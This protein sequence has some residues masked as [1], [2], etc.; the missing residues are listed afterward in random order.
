MGGETYGEGLPDKL[1][2]QELETD[3]PVDRS[4]RID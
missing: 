4:L 1:S 2:I 3:V